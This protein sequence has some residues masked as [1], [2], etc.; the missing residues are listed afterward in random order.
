VLEVAPFLTSDGVQLHLEH[1][2]SAAPL[3]QK[4][5]EGFDRAVQAIVEDNERY[6]A[7]VQFWREALAD[8]PLSNI[9]MF[10]S[11]EDSSAAWTSLPCDVRRDQVESI[12]AALHCD[13]TVVLLSVL[14]V[15]LSRLNG[16]EDVVVLT[17]I[18]GTVVPL[19]LNPS[20][21]LGFEKFV[22]QVREKLKLAHEH[23][24]GASL[25]DVTFDVG[26]A[27]EAASFEKLQQNL[28][29]VLEATNVASRLRREATEQILSYLQA[30]VSDVAADPARALGNIVLD[31]TQHLDDPSADLAHDVFS[32]S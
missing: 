24:A 10:G 22:Q 9:Q 11:P 3:A 23:S 14:S 16:R 4:L 13:S 7:D 5:V 1:E 30:I 6:L 21:N 2:S 26:F 18:G 31:K 28:T 32:F 29:L 27:D 20:W 8:A 12:C 15:L 25:V 17:S 19:R